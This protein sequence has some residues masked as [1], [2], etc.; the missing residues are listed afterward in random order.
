MVFEGRKGKKKKVKEKNWF[1]E[2]R[3][4][5]LGIQPPT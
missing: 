1:T 5:G 4:D 2:G 3:G